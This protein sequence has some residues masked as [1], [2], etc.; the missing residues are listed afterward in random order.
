MTVPVLK[1]LRR[2][3]PTLRI[4][5]LTR[6]FFQ[7]FFHDVEGIEFLVPDLN[8]RH[9]GLRG[10]WR[11]AAEARRQGIDAVADLHDVL[12]SQVI[13]RLLRLNGCSVAHIRKGRREKRAL[14]RKGYLRSHPLKTTIERYADVF[15]RLDLP[16]APLF[17][18]PHREH[19][20][21]ETVLALTGEKNGCWIGFAPF[22][23][24]RGKTY[25]QELATQLTALL[26]EKAEKIFLFGGGEQER[27]SAESMAAGHPNVIVV[28]GKL[29]LAGELEL[30]AHLDAIVTMDSSAM[31]MASLVGTPAVSIWGATHPYAGFLGFGQDPEQVVQLPL[32]CRPCSVFGDKPC[33]WG[34]WRCLHG[35]DPREIAAKTLL[36]CGKSNCEKI[37][38]RTPEIDK[39][40]VSLQSK[41]I[42]HNSN[43]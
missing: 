38:N 24:H 36:L 11:L 8:G 35:I 9:K 17:P 13:R 14:I 3:N 21:S 20:L 28:V 27:Q 2:A 41:P 37:H 34:D 29:K 15:R 10:L 4:T 1:A 19:P 16:L 40:N 18:E 22:A 5:V 6:P 32:P 25:P 12:R 39:I 7:P 26:S 23:K 42:E 33:R 30:I 43:Q 31:H